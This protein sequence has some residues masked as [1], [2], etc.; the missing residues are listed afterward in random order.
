MAETNDIKIKVGMENQTGPGFEK[1]NKSVESLSTSVFKGVASW[2]LL[3]G[4]VL[5]ATDFFK[6]SIEASMRANAEMAQVRNNV[7]NAGFAYDEIGGK[8]E[9]YSKKM[10]KMGFDD[11]E[12]A[13]S[14][15]KLLLVTKD[16]EK[17]INL[18]NLAM[19]VARYKNIDLESASQ[20]VRMAVAGNVKV[21][22]D[23]GIEMDKNSTAGER[24]DAIQKNVTNSAKTYAESLEG[25]LRT[26]Q[27]EFGNFKESMG[28]VFGPALSVALSNF[29]EFLNTS[30]DNAQTWSQSMA[31]YLAIIINPKTYLAAGGTALSGLLSVTS[32]VQ[33]IFGFDKAAADSK[34]AAD[35]LLESSGK[36]ADSVIDTAY[37]AMKLRDMAKTKLP[38]NDNLFSG[39]GN[40]AKS[41]AEK[42]KN[43]IDD[44]KKK[45]DDYNDKIKETK[46]NI[47]DESAAFIAAQ[48]DK[49]ASFTE[50]LA[51]M[52]ASHKEKWE[53][54]NRDINE[55]KT[56]G[57]DIDGQKL[58]ELQAIV[59]KEFAIV[60]PYLNR[61]DL[62]AISNKSD[63]EKLIESRNVEM[64][65]D[66][67]AEGKKMQEFQ[68]QTAKLVMNFDLKGSTVTDK[69]L[70]NRI[71]AELN[72]G[73][74]ILK[75]VN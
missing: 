20:L 32:K 62:T 4:A 59:Q 36:M 3:K 40:D 51:S 17:A 37:Q 24:L 68:D 33:D 41:A 66:T 10:I 30:N 13:T 47:Q 67:V 6:T 52:V 61:T 70:I 28:D 1:L 55:M 31:K 46:R 50:Q 21:L 8:L 38:S 48:R 53:Q 56:K 27:V 26:L 45:F 35:A 39:I 18:N 64:A 63:I 22:K 73:M 34:R 19:D 43:A 58:L 57:G 2:D 11:E 60:Q 49:N 12:T 42:A 14:V 75:L 25:K 15:S 54:A 16:Y 74:N 72:K 9:E 29:N 65:K 69:D 23:F 5:K 7:Q 44:L 71:K